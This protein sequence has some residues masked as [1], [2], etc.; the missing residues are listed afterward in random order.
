MVEEEPD[1]WLALKLVPRLAISKKLALV[2]RY[3]LQELF[4]ASSWQ[5]GADLTMPQIKAFQHPDW[6]RVKQ[7]TAASSLC[8]SNIIHYNSPQYPELLKQLPDPPLVLFVQGNSALL[9]KTQLAIVG[10]RFATAAGR[11]EATAMAQALGQQG[12]VITSGLA[13]GIDGAAHRGALLE[14]SGTVAVVATGLDKVYPARH[15]QLAQN[16]LTNQGCIISEFEP[17]IPPKAGHFPRRN[18]L[19]SGLSVGVLVVE[20]AMKSGSLITAR[21]ALEQNREVFA[22]PGTIH[23]PQSK[24]CHWL[25]KQ[26]AKLVEECADII[27]ELDLSITSG[28]SKE[29]KEKK[30]K[31][32]QQ[33]LFLDPLLASVD[34]EITPVDMVVSRCKLP[35]DVVLTRLTMLELRGLVSAVPGGYL[36]LNRG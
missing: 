2:D 13:I 9:K 5:A 8:Q 20:A 18:R 11:D 19:I 36:R 14:K 27:E 26:G 31:T 29:K 22:M 24:G 30:E 7:I 32:A 17:G 4:T 25:I 35:T 1:Y 23:N 15:R 33:D 21:C 12:L 10:S 16:I 28:L 3:G 6:N 34:F